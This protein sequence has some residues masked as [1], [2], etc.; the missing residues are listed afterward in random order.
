MLRGYWPDTPPPVP[1]PVLVPISQAAA[2]AAAAFTP[3]VHARAAFMAAKK[4]AAAT[5]RPDVA[6]TQRKANEAEWK[7][8]HCAEFYVLQKRAQSR[9]TQAS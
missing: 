2:A 5:A 3:P 6:G 8:V 4:Q 1:P 7:T 9:P